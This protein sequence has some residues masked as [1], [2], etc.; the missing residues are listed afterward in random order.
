MAILK[1]KNI[2]FNSKEKKVAIPGKIIATQNVSISGKVLVP[3]IKSFNPIY[4]SSVSDFLSKQGDDD[5]NL[6]APS[7]G[8]QIQEKFDL[9]QVRRDAMLQVQEEMNTYRMNQKRLLDE[10]KES[11]LKNAHDVGYF[12]G[13]EKAEREQEEK[14]KE[15]LNSINQMAVE[16]R[17]IIEELEP[18]LMTLAIAIAEK[19]IQTQVERHPSVFRHILEEALNKIT[20][21]DSVLIKVN[22]KDLEFVKSYKEV[23]QKELSDFKRIDIQQDLNID[24]GG[25]VIETKLG[26]IDSSIATK[27]DLIQ[28][29]FQK[30]LEE[31]QDGKSKKIVSKKKS[32]SIEEIENQRDDSRLNLDLETSQVR[33]QKPGDK[34]IQKTDTVPEQDV[35]HSEQDPFSDL[36]QD[37]LFEDTSLFDE[38]DSESFA[39]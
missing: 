36:V 5:S 25:C 20:D 3:V 13:I 6:S 14:S 19:V 27:L 23:Y 22:P 9:D 16:K 29:A 30:I 12:Q 18:Q 24:R 33:N 8:F 35:S 1:G 39:F 15:L 31:N 38:L 28:K 7:S 34:T 2:Q 26:F 11:T 32:K 17:R 10:E 37:D 21:K 4:T